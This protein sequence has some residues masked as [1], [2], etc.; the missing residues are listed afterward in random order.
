[1]RRDVVVDGERNEVFTIKLGALS[2]ALDDFVVTIPRI[3]GSVA[4]VLEDR[5]QSSSV[6]D[7]LGAEELSR[8]P[9]GS[10]SAASRRI[11][12][13]SVIGGQFLVVRGLGGRYTSVR[14]NMYH[15]PLPTPD[16]PGSDGPVSIQLVVEFD[17][18]KDLSC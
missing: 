14:L 5:R 10:A 16:M 4:K 13:A 2:L 6:Q 9:D 11:V 7:G 15:C 18:R 1:M 17:H 8:S 3:S 12:G